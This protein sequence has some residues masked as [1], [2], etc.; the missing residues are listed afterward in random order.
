[1]LPFL[2]IG[3][4]DLA[5]HRKAPPLTFFSRPSPKAGRELQTALDRIKD[6]ELTNGPLASRSR[7][8]G[9]E[10]TQR[11]ST[12]FR[13]DTCEDITKRENNTMKMVKWFS[14][15]MCS[16]LCVP[17]PACRELVG[18]RIGRETVDIWGDRVQ[19][20]TGL[21]GD[22]HRQKHDTVKLRL[23][24]LANECRLPASCEVFSA[25]EKCS[26]KKP[27]IVVP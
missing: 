21:T 14:E 24:N 17:S 5:Q 20:Q 12:C 1:M 23:Y 7:S 3:C 25:G 15:V 8:P 18:Q 16:Y 6:N 27:H 26:V 19:A 10:S 13:N 4:G 9:R 11:L 2:E 22:A